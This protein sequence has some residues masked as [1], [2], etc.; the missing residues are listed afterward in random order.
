ML[1]SIDV[2]SCSPDCCHK[3]TLELST[4]VMLS[5][6]DI[7]LIVLIV[8]MVCL[9]RAAGTGWAWVGYSPT[10]VDAIYNS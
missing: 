5:L 4:Q 10:K 1:V 3:P 9:Y 2:Q 6:Q 8:A 7:L